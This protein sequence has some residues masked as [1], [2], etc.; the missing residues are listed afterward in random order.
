MRTVPFTTDEIKSNFVKFRDE[1]LSDNEF[2]AIDEQLFQKPEKLHLTL[3]MLVL[4]NEQLERD[5]CEALKNCKADIIDKVLEGNLL[6]VELSGISI[7]NNDPKRV[8][9]L[10]GKIQS[11]KLQKIANKITKYF[12]VKGLIQVI[13]ADV[14]LHVTLMNVS[15]LKK[16]AEASTSSR[17][18]V[19][20]PKFDASKVF[21]KYKNFHFG[22]LTLSEV[23]ISKLG[24]KEPTGFYESLDVLTL[25]AV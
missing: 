10:Y 2:E 13:R 24:G 12:A 18:F 16:K 8:S 15:F 1:I 25:S 5:A 19:Q 22:S 4:S 20:R 7:M 23:R 14:T 21:E 17:N 6:N 9:V 11:E 3:T